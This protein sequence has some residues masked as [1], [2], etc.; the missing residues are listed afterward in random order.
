MPNYEFKTSGLLGAAFPWSYR[1]RG[2]S[3]AS[4]ATLAASFNTAALALWN[5]TT[6]GLKNFTSADV[7]TTKTT[8]ATLDATMHWVTATDTAL[9]VTGIDA[10]A[11]LPWN[12]A[13]VVSLRSAGRTKSSHGRIYLPPFAED[14]VVAHVI[15]AATTAKMKI[16]FDAFWTAIGTAGVIPFVVNMKPLKNGSP[17]FTTKSFISYDISDKPAQQRRRVSKIVPTRVSGAIP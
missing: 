10:N 14:Q 15:L 12:V 7:T 17:A 5:T 11:S 8:V 6:N 1:F 4:E 3:A 2:S 13:E 9:T 16:V